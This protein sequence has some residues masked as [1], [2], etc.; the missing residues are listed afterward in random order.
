MMRTNDLLLRCYAERTDGV[1]SAICLDLNLASQGDTLADAQSEL[2]E[3]IVSYLDD[4]LGGRDEAFSSEL[5]KRRAPL[6]FFFKY[7]RVRLIDRLRDHADRTGSACHS[8]LATLPVR[9]QSSGS[10]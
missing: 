7:Y 5:L 10:C 4:A 6:E 3:Q 9:L 1:W 2:N 8:F